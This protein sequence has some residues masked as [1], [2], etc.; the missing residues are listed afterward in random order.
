MY[1][2]E[3]YKNKIQA[4]YDEN[5]HITTRNLLDLIEEAIVD[6]TARPQ[7][8]FKQPTWNDFWD[9]ECDEL[10]DNVDVGKRLDR[11]G[12]L[13]GYER[14]KNESNG[15]Y[16]KRL[17]TA[18]MKCTCSR[19]E[20]LDMLFNGVETLDCS[21]NDLDEI[22]TQ[23]GT[24]Q[25]EIDSFVKWANDRCSVDWSRKTALEQI[26]NQTPLWREYVEDNKVD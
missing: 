23:W 16:C 12:S 15:A 21:H 19:E 9:A 1:N 26:T 18:R 6:T 14:K 5:N 2:R 24:S 20:L 3:D 10:G 13:F 11:Y 7:E 25:Y 8:E 22:A 17:Y 4:M